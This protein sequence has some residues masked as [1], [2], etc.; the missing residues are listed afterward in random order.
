M[1]SLACGLN[2]SASGEIASSTP[3]PTLTRTPLPTLTLTPVSTPV[4]LAMTAE[5]VET[6]GDQPAQSGSVAVAPDTANTGSSTVLA[7]AP[8]PVEVSGAGEGT[9]SSSTSEANLPQNPVDDTAASFSDTSTATVTA[10]AT[11]PL[12]SSPSTT[13]AEVSQSVAP[14]EQGDGWSFVN[15]QTYPAPNESDFLLNGEMVN[16]TGVAQEVGYI[17]GIFYDGQGQ[18]IADEDNIFDDWPIDIVPAG[19]RVPFKLTVRGIQEAANFEM[20]VAADPND[21]PPHQDFEFLAVNI[22]SEAEAY[23]ITGRLQNLGSGL[24]EYLVTIATLFNNQGQVISFGA[25]YEPGVSNIVDA[26]TSNFDVCVDDL[27]Q[28]VARYELQA[29][30]R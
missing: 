29:W 28:T 1:V 24:E 7:E 14:I 9:G 4:G 20:R 27:K 2:R 5:E 16:D 22:S 13:G 11:P 18:V 21:E 26:A 25:Y 23:C 3:L 8:V 30:G 19:G 15:L 12:I 10:T 17:T 6:V